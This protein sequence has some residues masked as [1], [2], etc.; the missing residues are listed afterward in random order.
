MPRVGWFASMFGRS[1]VEDAKPTVE[2]GDLIAGIIKREGGYVCHPADRGG[3]T[4]WGITL[5]T[6]QSTRKGM[7]NADDVA[8]LT[9]AEAATIYRE[10]YLNGPRISTLPVVVQAATLD[11]AVHSGPRRAITMLQRACND[12]LPKCDPLKA[13]GIIGPATR[14]RVVKAIN[15]VSGAAVV[16]ALCD[17]RIAHLKAIVRGDKSQRAFIKGWQRR[18][19]ELRI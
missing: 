18:V 7:V 13:D 4:N 5:K 1:A 12:L 10:R 16:N 14:L 3:P 8:A 15:E 17:L 2:V 11:Y 19:N 9:R 6:L